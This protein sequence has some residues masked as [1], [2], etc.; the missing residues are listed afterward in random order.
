MSHEATCLGSS[1]LSPEASRAAGSK[2]GSR[3]SFSVACTYERFRP[4]LGKSLG[5]RSG[6]PEGVVMEVVINGR[7]LKSVIDATQGARA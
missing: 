1:C 2:A 6:L 7:D 4:T 3:Y 5:S